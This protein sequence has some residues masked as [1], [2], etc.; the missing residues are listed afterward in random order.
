MSCELRGHP[1]KPYIKYVLILGETVGEIAYAYDGRWEFHRH[2]PVWSNLPPRL[3]A[4]AE[5]FA[6][7]K[8]TVLNVTRRLTS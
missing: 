3:A 6:N 8:C 7:E 5:T 4:E 1:R 2:Q